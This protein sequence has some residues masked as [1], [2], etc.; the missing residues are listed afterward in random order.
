MACLKNKQCIKFGA[1]ILVWKLA[2]SRMQERGGI[3]YVILQDI[4]TK[5]LIRITSSHKIIA[6]LAYL[7]YISG[8]AFSSLTMQTL[9][10]MSL[11]Q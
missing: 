5:H 11:D 6:S 8:A 10:D 1:I 4:N 7:V 3:L 9:A 2:H